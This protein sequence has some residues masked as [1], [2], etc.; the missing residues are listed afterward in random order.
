M[1]DFHSHRNDLVNL[2]L[3]LTWVSVSS[4]FAVGHGI[5]SQPYMSRSAQ[6]PIG[7]QPHMSRRSA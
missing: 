7:S 2:L 3:A 6:H 1:H 4:Q 5:A